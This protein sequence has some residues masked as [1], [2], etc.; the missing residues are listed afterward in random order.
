MRKKEKT[1]QNTVG[2]H[3]TIY[4]KNKRYEEVKSSQQLFELASAEYRLSCST[5]GYYKKVKGRTF[6]WIQT[7]YNPF[8]INSIII[9]TL[10]AQNGTLAACCILLGIPIGTLGWYTGLVHIGKWQH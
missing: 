3:F 7:I 1:C 10:R 5:L 9:Q 4:E 8:F 6:W 2:E